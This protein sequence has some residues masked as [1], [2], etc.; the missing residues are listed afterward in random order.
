MLRYRT[1][2]LVLVLTKYCSKGFSSCSVSAES[3]AMIRGGHVDFTVLGAFEVDVNG[4]IASWMIPG[5][6]VKGMGG[7]MDLVAGAKNIIVTMTHTD[8]HGNSKLLSECTLP[9]TG[10]NCITR[11]ITDLAV[12]EVAE[13]AFVLK[14]T[15][16]G[17]TVDEIQQKTQGKLVVPDDVNVMV[18]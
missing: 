12:L 18:V 8:K 2:V 9:L 11:I 6:L 1:S 3:F 5:K 10:V 16:P 7:A 13:G 4:N 14:E 15:A 17:V